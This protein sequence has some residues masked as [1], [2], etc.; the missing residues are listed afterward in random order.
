[1]ALADETP[2]TDIHDHGNAAERIGAFERGRDE[3]AVGCL[4]AP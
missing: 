1:M 2:W 4:P 3:G